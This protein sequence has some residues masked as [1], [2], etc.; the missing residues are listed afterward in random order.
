MI[1]QKIHLNQ[2]QNLPMRVRENLRQ[3]IIIG[4]AR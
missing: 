4:F 1:R 3:E 2:L